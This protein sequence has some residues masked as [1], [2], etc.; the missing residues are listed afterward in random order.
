MVS[1][2][3]PPAF[4]IHLTAKYSDK[5]EASAARSK[6]SLFD[7]QWVKGHQDHHMKILPVKA[8]LNILTDL[9]AIFFWDHPRPYLIPSTS[10]FPTF[11]ASLVLR[12]INVTKNPHTMS[13]LPTM[14]VS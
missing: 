7:L 13:T 6:L 3:L 11:Q 5:A 1:E 9:H 4:S 10:H 14:A 8:L 2:A 12:G